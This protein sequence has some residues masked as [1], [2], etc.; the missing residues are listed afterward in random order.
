[1][2]RGLRRPTSSLKYVP[3]VVLPSI[4]P[5]VWKDGWSPAFVTPP[6]TVGVSKVT[7]QTYPFDSATLVVRDTVTWIDKR[8]PQQVR[9]APVARN[10]ADRVFP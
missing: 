6:T 8:Q 3:D 4:R 10:E 5:F 9:G 1:M 7:L 2:M